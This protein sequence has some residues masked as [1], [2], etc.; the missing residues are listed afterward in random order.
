MFES[1]KAYLSLDQT[2]QKIGDT[3]TETLEYYCAELNNVCTTLALCHALCDQ[4]ANNEISVA[5]LIKASNKLRDVSL[6]QQACLVAVVG[7]CNDDG[8]EAILQVEVKNGLYSI[9]LQQIG[10]VGR[11]QVNNAKLHDQSLIL[12]EG[13][14][15][16]PTD[17]DSRAE[18]TSVSDIVCLIRLCWYENT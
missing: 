16:T 5:S 15:F 3:V 7:S 6:L 17:L 10:K 4:Y 9:A 2:S 13:I 18:F 11:V 12:D 14:K 1:V 8:E